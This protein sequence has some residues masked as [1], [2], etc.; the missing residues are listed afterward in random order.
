MIVDLLDYYR[1]QTQSGR[2][3]AHKDFIDR[4]FGDDRVHFFTTVPDS[5]WL[6]FSTVV[7]LMY[8]I[9]GL[10]PSGPGLNIVAPKLV[11]LVSQLPVIIN[12]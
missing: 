2:T 10:S 8:W 9:Q 6:V 3:D 5:T 7:E 11:L 1:N 4:S 12:C